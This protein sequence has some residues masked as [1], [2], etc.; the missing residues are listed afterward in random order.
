[1]LDHL[2]NLERTHYCGDLRTDHVGQT[3]TL[4]GWVNGRRDHG[5]LTFVDLRDRE[6]F[7]QVVLNEERAGGDAHQ[8]GKTIRNEYVICVRGTVVRRSEETINPKIPTGEIEVHVTEM[9]VLNDAKTTPI[10]LND[11]KG[12]PAAEDTRLKYRYLDLRRPSMQANIRLRHK[13]TSTIRSYMDGQGFLEIETPM[14]IRSTPEGARDFIVPSRLHAGEFYALPQS[15]QLFKQLLMIAGFDRYFQIARCFRDE[16]LRADRQ[17]EFT[18]LD[19]EMSFPRMETVFQVMEGLVVELCA[20]KNI[21]VTLPLPRMTYDEAMRRY[22]SD[23]PDTRFGMELVDLTETVRGSDFIPYQK[24]LESNGQVK[25]IVAKG[26]ADYARKT[27]D[28][29][30]DWLR[31]DFKAGGLGYAKVLAEGVSSPLTKGVGEELMA[32]IV[33]ATGAETGD[34]VF[35]VAGSAA[36]VAAAL[37]ALRLEIGK[38][39]KL[40]DPNQFNFLWVTEFPMF[41]YHEEDNRW[42]AMHHPFTSPRD[43]D[44]ERFAGENPDLGGVRAKAYDLV[45]NGVEIGGGSIR[46]HRQDIQQQIFRILGFTDEDARRR[47]GFF[48]DALSYGTPPHGGIALGLDRLVMLFSGESSIRDVMAFPKTASASDLMCE[49]PGPVDDY[50]LKELRLKIVT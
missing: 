8:R 39:E 3:V 38:R 1:M 16:D 30:T 27:L 10:P 23:K 14:L 15:P 42:Y 46:I 43:E 45:L 29:F 18:Q 49:S 50:Q 22:G 28:D 26:K 24:A 48:M 32:K 20:L 34:M 31:K 12:A 21:P 2:G 40:Y 6:G 7:V 19:V 44:L 5:P 36:V 13:M 41:E 4:M 47:F 11:D 17:P 35:I 33:A 25:A 37:S 9:Y